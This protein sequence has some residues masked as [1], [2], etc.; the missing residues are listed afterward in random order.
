VN[1][2]EHI[3]TFAKPGQI[4]ISRSFH[5]V[6]SRLSD[7]PTQLFASGGTH[8][9]KNGREHEIFM[10][11][12]EVREAAAATTDP[13][14]RPAT[15]FSFKPRNAVIGAVALV[16]RLFSALADKARSIARISPPPTPIAR[17]ATYFPPAAANQGIRSGTVRARLDIDAAGTV[18][19]VTIL[20]ADPPRV[21][22]PEA[23]R[24][25][26]RWRFDSGADGRTYE[27]VLDFKR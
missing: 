13:A 12:E 23:I 19:R 6:V 11:G 24:S 1:V 16:A 5:D 25:L 9:D 18:T 26:Q 10:V 15:V 21:F 2:A 27:A 8:T 17:A 14:I 22:D 20:A 3:V 7:T 4:V